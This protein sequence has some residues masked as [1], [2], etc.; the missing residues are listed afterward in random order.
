[1]IADVSELIRILKVLF[2]ILMRTFYLEMNITNHPIALN[3]LVEE[4]IFS[5]TL[6][7]KLT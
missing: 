3:Q 1:M 2:Q 4:K 5:G 6:K 7:Q